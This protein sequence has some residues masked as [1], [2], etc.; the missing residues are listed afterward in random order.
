MI[1]QALVIIDQ[2]RISQH[3]QDFAFAL[4]KKKKIRLTA[5]G[6][7]DTPWLT[8][9]Q[10]EPLGGMSVKI[11]GDE[12]LVRNTT[13]TTKIYLDEF[14]ASAQKAKIPCSI[15]QVD[16]VPAVEV[17]KISQEYDFIITPP[18]IDLHH[19]LE[20]P[21]LGFLI[22]LGQTTARPIYVIPGAYPA[23]SKTVILAF[24]GSASASKAIY[25]YILMGFAKG[26]DLHVISVDKNIDQA[27]EHCR[28]IV[29]LANS[30]GLKP[31]THAITSSTRPEGKVLELVDKVAAAEIVMGAFG[32]SALHEML[33]GSCARTLLEKAK[34][35][36][37]I[38]H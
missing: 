10:P 35:P 27:E 4:A 23:R 11:R 25:L 9:A 37:F 34:I 14:Y 28:Q 18:K 21:N 29:R 16:G 19:E 20:K 30:H 13:H 31:Q 2:S 12:A 17:N 3:A 33:F 7:V 6:I 22:D 32:H 26:K 38:H 8:A 5:V 36:L 24:D 1:R 15:R